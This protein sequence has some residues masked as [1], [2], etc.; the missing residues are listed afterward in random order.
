MN[1]IS[2]LLG[3]LFPDDAEASFSN[4]RLWQ[5]VGHVTLYISRVYLCSMAVLAL[6]LVML[7][8]AIMSYIA[9]EIMIKL[10]EQ[11]RRA[12]KSQ[13]QNYVMPEFAAWIPH[14]NP[15]QKGPTTDLFNKRSG[16][17][18]EMEDLIST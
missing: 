13:N 16:S 12:R 6:S 18:C 14:V 11:E 5:M 4:F 7:I 3:L 1:Y 10:H 17:T 15:H 9:L 8:L 2:A